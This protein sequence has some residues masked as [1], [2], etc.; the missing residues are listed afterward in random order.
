MH[1]TTAVQASP[2]ARDS[3]SASAPIEYELRFC[4]LFHPGRALSFRCDAAGVVDMNAMSPRCLQNYLFARGMIGREYAYPTVMA[5][6]V[7]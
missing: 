6:S 4:S 1:S 5:C 2:Q 7:H 3:S